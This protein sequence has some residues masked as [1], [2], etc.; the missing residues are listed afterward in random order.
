MK[1]LVIILF[2]SILLTNCVSYRADYI[3]GMTDVDSPTGHDDIYK[4]SFVT[5]NKILESYT[6][7]DDYINISWSFDYSELDFELTNKTNKTIKVI[8]DDAAYVDENGNSSNIMHNGVKYTDRNESQKASVIIKKGK[9]NDAILPTSKA[10]YMPST[11]YSA[12]GWNHSPLFPRIV[13]TSQDALKESCEGIIG[14]EVKVLLPI[15]I[16]EVIYEYI[17]TFRVEDLIIITYQII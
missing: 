15:E 11:Q 7:E 16:D 1:N 14:L 17:F 2:A 13:E 3:V 4:D 12:G 10:Y 9:L 6:F 8:W 5:A